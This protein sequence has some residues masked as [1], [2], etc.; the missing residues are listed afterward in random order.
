MREQV[1]LQVC[2]IRVDQAPEF[3]GS[4]QTSYV[5]PLIHPH[6]DHRVFLVSSHL[7]FAHVSDHGCRRG[8]EQKEIILEPHT[9]MHSHTHTHAC[10][11]AGKIRHDPS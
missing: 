4:T 8:I 3:P 2:G 5:G 6:V 1:T 7:T 11:V 9:I 10:M